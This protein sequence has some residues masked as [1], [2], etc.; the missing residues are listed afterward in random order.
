MPISAFRESPEFPRHREV[1][2][3]DGMVRF[4]NEIQKCVKFAHVHWKICNIFTLIYGRIA[5]I[6]ASYRTASII[7]DSGIKWGRYHVP[8]NAF[9]VWTKIVRT[10]NARNVWWE[11]W[12][13]D[14]YFTM[15]LYRWT[16]VENR[17]AFGQSNSLKALK[18][19]AYINSRRW[20]CT[21]RVLSE[22][23]KYNC[24]QH[25][26][27]SNIIFTFTPPTSSRARHVISSWIYNNVNTNSCNSLQKV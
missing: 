19:V 8:Q 13:L 11:L 7:M 2:E 22:L 26:L 20:L 25:K 12:C 23:V 10:N 5:N 9:L 15:R 17:S 21:N 24:M 14:P 6:P 27:T 18:S 1:E 3:H 4:Q 16:G